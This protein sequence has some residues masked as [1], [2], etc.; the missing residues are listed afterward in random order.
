MNITRFDPLREMREITRFDPFREMRDITRTFQQFTDLANQLVKSEG[1]IASF[2]PTV[3][4]R[5][6]EKGYYIEVD[7]PGVKKEDIH[8]DVKE[9]ILTIS[10]E[11]KVKK[12]VKREDYYKL[13][14]SFG[15]FERSFTLPD[16]VDVDKIEA[17][18]EDGVLNIT[19]PKKVEEKQ[20]AKKIEVK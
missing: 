17:K 1:S 14:S 5:E 8:L 4:T 7:L 13:E 2:V 9:N 18:T 12:E 11:R 15:K 3:N 10:G 20:Q 6:D 16:D 19:L